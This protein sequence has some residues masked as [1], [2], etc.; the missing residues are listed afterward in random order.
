[1]SPALLDALNPPQREAAIHVDGPV[2][3]LAGAGSGKTRV[4][5]YRVAHLIDE[6][7]VAPWHI[8]AV[9][10]TNKA[11]G[12]MRHRIEQLVGTA[13]QHLWV[14]TFHSIG[15]R[16]LR[17][18]SKE[19]G[20]DG[21]FTVYDEDDRRSLMRRLFAERDLNDQDLDPKAVLNQISRSKTAMIDAQSAM[22]Q[23]GDSPRKRK[24]AEMY[25]AY[26]AALRA[27]NAFDF[28]DLIVEPVRQLN[29]CPAVLER[30]GERFQ[31]VLIDEYQDTNQPQYLFSKLMAS[32]HRNICCVGDD[33]QSIY[34]FRG[35]DIRNILDFEND[36][37]DAQVVRLEQNYRS[38]SRILSVANAVIENNRDR[39]GKNLWT[40]GDQGELIQVT[41][42]ADDRAEARRA[43]GTVM[44]VCGREGL[45][46]GEAVI[47]YRTNAQSRPL[48]EEL[49]RV[50]L[51]YTIVGGIRFY[52]RKEIKDLVAYLRIVA[53]PADDVSLLRVINVPKRGIG[54]TTIVRLR[55]FANDRGMPLRTALEH[56]DQVPGLNSRAQTNLA[57]FRDLIGE[58][59]VVDRASPGAITSLAELV[60]EQTG[61]REVLAQERTPEAETREL[62]L[63]QLLGRIAEFEE[64]TE[65]STLEGFLEEVALMTPADDAPDRGESLTLMTLHMAKGLE[66]PLVVICGLEEN[67]F[68][69]A[70]SIE[71][72]HTNRT[73]IEEER[74][75]LYVGITR[76]RRF[77]ALTHA[78]WRFMYGSVQ[79]SVPSRFLAEIPQEFTH[80][81]AEPERFQ[82]P[83]RQS[84]Q[85][86]IV[87]KDPWTQITPSVQPTA[88][89]TGVHYEFDDGATAGQLENDMSL[90]DIL[91]VGRWV[92][93]PS[94][95][96]GQII[97]RDGVG[98]DTK[99]TIRFSRGQV[100]KV[101]VAYASLEPA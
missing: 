86:A 34:Q 31:Q 75:L 21:N 49:Q 6:L 65:A 98:A 88:K 101:V 90:D 77:L 93:H 11:A 30:Y 87:K 58:L 14:G 45:T 47:L 66:Y 27:C 16:F 20:I 56:L 72:S 2:L 73:A 89:A 78:R 54:N 62:N 100:K 4:L 48:E 70:R 80:R 38:T 24:I 85:P 1:M 18:E 51:P 40:A 60:L 95:G 10:F 35:A 79:E 43:V 92:L 76:A 82:R 9:T 64:K 63:D 7:G 12:E 36:Y 84:V 96:R 39:K 32:K 8:L 5:T 94:W 67:L 57:G 81:E 29:R 33:D 50:G 37:P 68:P 23:A 74:R 42:C 83:R 52:E 46:T 61:Y 28:D 59:D 99:L 26:Q 44:T 19:L 22:D 55:D 53:N 97:A 91:A 15:A 17:Y 3:V 69:T 71:E 25:L 41:E 13:A